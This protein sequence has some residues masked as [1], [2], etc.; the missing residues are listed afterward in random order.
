M[1]LYAIST[2][3]K[4]LEIQSNDSI[5]QERKEI[6]KE[7]LQNKESGGASAELYLPPESFLNALEYLGGDN[8]I[9]KAQRNRQSA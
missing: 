4:P 5:S 6:F 8:L 1:Q 2:N 7:T 9:Y 3:Y